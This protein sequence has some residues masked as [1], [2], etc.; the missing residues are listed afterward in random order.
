MIN[1]KHISFLFIGILF[2]CGTKITGIT[3]RSDPSFKAILL[4]IDEQVLEKE[5]FIHV[6]SKNTKSKET[7]VSRKE[8]EEN[9]ELYVN[10]RLKVKYAEDLEL[11]QKEG[12]ITEFETYK[13]DIKKPFL[14]E[15]NVK[16]KEVKDAY[17]R[18]Q[19]LIKASHI[20]IQFPQGAKSEDSVAVLKMAEKIKALANGGEDF[21]ELALK[22]SEDPSVENNQG[23]LGYFTALQMVPPFEKAAF[24]LSPGEI[25]N[26]V[27]T[28]FGIHLIQLE[29]TIPNPGE[30]RVSHILLRSLPAST[31]SEESA[32]RKINLIYS[33]LKEDPDIWEEMVATFSEDQGSKDNRGFIPW[34]GAGGIVPEIEKAAF[35][36]KNIGDISAPVKTDYGYHIIRLEE[37][38]PLPPIEDLE[39]F[40]KSRLFRN[41]DSKILKNQVLKSQMNKFNVWE[42]KDLKEKLEGIDGFHLDIFLSDARNKMNPIAPLVRS[43]Q[44]TLFIED[45]AAFVENEFSAEKIKTDN[46]FGE[47]Y[48]RF[49]E[50]KLS[51]WEEEDLFRHNKE[52]R[53]LINEYRNGIL[54]F[55]L[56]NELVWQKAME[57]SL[58][59]IRY[60]QSNQKD[61]R[62]EE[63]VSAAIIQINKDS[64]GAA[65]RDY[66]VG[67]RY[68]ENIEEE[69]EEKFLRE[70]P[71]LFGVENGVFE[72]KKHEILKKI[73][74]DLTFHE[75]NHQGKTCYVLLGEKIPAKPKA[76]EET[77]GKLIQDYQNHLESELILQLKEK[78]SIQINEDEKNRIYQ[79]LNQ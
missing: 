65:I 64:D 40:I 79:D 26:P 46:S 20:L 16:D 27:F 66:L 74:T 54:I 63:R 62:W 50:E 69:L 58:G 38:R 31:A 19:K 44:D 37:K 48:E 14:L 72:I 53:L 39:E 8:F 5:E 78:Y 7:K 77:R 28:D 22:Y 35:S 47:V 75:L 42:N 11:D 13:A 29:E 18:M 34:F 36:L 71:L 76:I 25:S 60:F 70:K 24:S 33:D 23:H 51:L 59:Q 52:Y 55:N 6:L 49:L 32:Q 56:M 30:V 67:S 57:D 1:L 43:D 68:H 21:N 3:N 15:S 73:N 10:Y 12:F 2:A 61:Y 9:F 17:A 41:S 4:Q 45:F